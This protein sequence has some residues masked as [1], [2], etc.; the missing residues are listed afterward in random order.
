MTEPP[1]SQPRSQ[2]SYD[3][4]DRRDGA[5]RCCPRR[6][7]GG[8][9]GGSRAAENRW[10]VGKPLRTS[11]RF[12][13]LGSGCQLG[14]PL[15][16]SEREAEV[17]AVPVPDPRPGQQIHCRVRRR[18]HRCRH[19]DHPHPP[20]GHR[21]RTAITERFIGTLHR[22]CLDHLL[23]TGPRHLE[24]VLREYVQHFNTHHLHRLLDQ[25]PPAGGTPQVPGRP[26]ACS[27][28]TG[29]AASS[30]NTLQVA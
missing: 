4:A 16:A 19:P 5:I 13:I 2:Q 18:L 12:D 21:G 6:T 9:L 22:E 24:A 8:G 23:I 29:S 11:A 3:T 1:R 17:R 30:T 7:C 14:I 20:C 28:K 15:Q 27:D 26:S 10:R 25:H